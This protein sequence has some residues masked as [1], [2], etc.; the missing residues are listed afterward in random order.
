[1]KSFFLM[2]PLL[3]LAACSSRGSFPSLQPRPGEIPRVIEAPGAGTAL[4]LPPEQRDS[5]KAD[6]Q[7]ETKILA[8]TEADVAR[9][10][11]ALDAALAKAKGAQKGSESWSDAQMALSRFDVARTPLGEIEARLTPLLRTTDSLDSDDPDRQ[12]VESLASA[13]ARASADAERRVQAATR[14]LGG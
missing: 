1:M 13:A 14:A 7:R 4:H 3:L 6:L 9:A 12:A 5:L 10:G 11:A 8:E 2:L